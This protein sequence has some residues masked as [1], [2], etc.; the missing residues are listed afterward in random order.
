[1]RLNVLN[2]L[3]VVGGSQTG[4]HMVDGDG[5][6]GWHHVEEQLGA[7]GHVPIIGGRSGA[8]QTLLRKQRADG[9]SDTPGTSPPVGADTAARLIC[10][11]VDF[12]ASIIS[13]MRWLACPGCASTRSACYNVQGYAWDRT[14]VYRTCCSCLF[15]LL[16]LTAWWC[17]HLI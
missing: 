10:R 13:Q 3:S 11:L 1:M 14:G 4:P 6:L 12:D 8:I 5:T 17:H 2:V 9:S 7:D 16:A 15:A